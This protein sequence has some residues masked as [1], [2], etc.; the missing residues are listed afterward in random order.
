MLMAHAVQQLALST[1]GKEA[2]AI[3]SVALALR[4]I[5][6]TL[7]DN[8]GYD[9]AEL[10]AQLRAGHAAGKTTLGLDM[11]RGTVG[12]LNVACVSD[13]CRSAMWRSWASPSR[14]RSSCRCSCRRQRPLR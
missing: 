3:E 13:V 8:G 2:D 12:A 4:K 5:P 1:P 7:A 10:V 6:I 14:S 11:E 9:S